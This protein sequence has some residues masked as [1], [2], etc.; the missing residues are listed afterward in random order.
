MDSADRPRV[1]VD[2]LR[3]TGHFIYESG[4]HGETWLELDGLFVDQRRLASIAEALA[5]RLRPHGVEVVCGP[6]IGGALLG[7]WV[8]HS[9]ALPFVYAER[10]PPAEDAPARYRIPPALT[11]TVA[12]RRVAIVDDAINAGSATLATR[13]EVARLGG[14][15]AVAASIF[16]RDPGG[17]SL[18]RASGLAV[19]YLV[20]LRFTIWPPSDCPLC[21]AGVPVERTA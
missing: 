2:E 10:T 14:T 13:D 3:K 1:A 18:L 5:V 11:T 17:I 21:H 16:L 20:G 8:A 7:Q 6:L 9:L 15:A 4:H 19:E 12:G